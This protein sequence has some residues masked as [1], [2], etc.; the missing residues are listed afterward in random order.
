MAER[1]GVDMDSAFTALRAYARSHN[2][3][4]GDMTRMVIT[5]KIDTDELLGKTRPTR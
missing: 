2:L 3:K 1:L 4:L 5:R